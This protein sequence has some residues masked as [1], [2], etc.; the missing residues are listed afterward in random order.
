MQVAWSLINLE[1]W[2]IIKSKPDIG[3][4][5]MKIEIYFYS[6]ELIAVLKNKQTKNQ[7]A[8]KQTNKQTNKR[9]N[10]ENKEKKN[11][12]PLWILL[13]QVFCHIKNRFRLRLILDH[14]KIVS[15]VLWNLRSSTY[16]FGLYWCLNV[17]KDRGFFILFT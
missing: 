12:F 13:F 9:T 5:V 11:R 4:S 8:S 3:K 16:E 14:C 2:E 17:S 15:Q 10:K 7:Q 1:G 6:C